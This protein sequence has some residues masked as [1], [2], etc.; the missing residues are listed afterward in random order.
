MLTSRD[1][2]PFL[3]MHSV[4]CCHSHPNIPRSDQQMKQKI[5]VANLL[6][7]WKKF[8]ITVKDARK[9]SHALLPP[10]EFL[11]YP[12]VKNGKL[13]RKNTKIHTNIHTFQLYDIVIFNI[14]PLM[15]NF[16]WFLHVLQLRNKITIFYEQNTILLLSSAIL[17]T[18]TTWRAHNVLD[19]G[20]GPKRTQEAQT[21]IRTSNIAFF[22]YF[23][24]V[25]SV[26]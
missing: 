23:Y 19:S 11:R 10:W 24:F 14:D 9:D 8:K 15:I 1:F 2:S 20:R 13:G 5:S 21:R 22:Q 17:N 16:L 26:I 4:L 6:W 7:H 25:I 3:V 18:L 12:R